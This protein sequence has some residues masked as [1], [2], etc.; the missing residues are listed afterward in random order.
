MKKALILLLAFLMVV[1]AG[2]GFGAAATTS[3]TAGTQDQ[4]LQDSQN[5]KITEPAKNTE[6]GNNKEK[7]F[8]DKCDQCDNCKENGC[9]HCDKCKEEIKNDDKDDVTVI[10]IQKNII[11]Y[12]YYNSAAAAGGAGANNAANKGAGKTVPMQKAGLPILPAILSTLMI[13]SGLLYGRLRN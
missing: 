10:I 3:D 7:K 12:L 6:T 13:G 5:N 9:D 4:T 11:S 2:M 1:S 8:R